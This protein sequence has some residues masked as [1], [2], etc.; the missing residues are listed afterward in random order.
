M[1]LD[2]DGEKTIELYVTP[3]L[4][5]F[6]G[7][8]LKLFAG[9]LPQQSPQ[10]TGKI[11]HMWLAAAGP[12]DSMFSQGLK[13]TGDSACVVLQPPDSALIA[14]LAALQPSAIV[15]NSK[16]DAALPFEAHIMSLPPAVRAVSA[17]VSLFCTRFSACTAGS[18]EETPSSPDS[19][20][21]R[22]HLDIGLPDLIPNTVPVT[23]QATQPP[24]AQ[25]ESSSA[26]KLCNQTVSLL[27]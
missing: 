17:F 26:A 13:L 23:K 16:A 5:Y 3:G 14:D 8:Q 24:Q 2:E 9:S 19:T 10:D 12:F 25:Q 6:V 20:G 27:R 22:Q 21:S 11:T 7:L 1:E 4:T 18:L 15:V